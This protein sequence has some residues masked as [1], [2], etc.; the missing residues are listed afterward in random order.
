M[1]EGI[2]EEAVRHAMGR[3]AR[4]CAYL[5]TVRPISSR[6]IFSGRYVE[7]ARRHRQAVPNV[8]HSLGCQLFGSSWNC[9][10][11]SWRHKTAVGSTARQIPRHLPRITQHS[12]LYITVLQQFREGDTFDDICS[13]AT[14]INSGEIAMPRVTKRQSNLTNVRRS[15]P[16][17]TTTC[18]FSAVHWY[19]QCAATGTGSVSCTDS[20]NTYTIHMPTLCE[21]CTFADTGDCDNDR[22]P[23]TAI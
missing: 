4:S 19:V 17:S 11:Y 5:P 16:T 15:V 22:Q 9:F 1:V 7:V 2:F 18:R 3:E 14:A 8:S 21:K 12:G 23:E 10:T 6:L 13:R 20:L